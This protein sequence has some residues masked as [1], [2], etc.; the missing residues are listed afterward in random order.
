MTVYCPL[1]QWQVWA[2][3]EHDCAQRQIK[4]QQEAADKA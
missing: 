3:G 2:I 1:C 4:R